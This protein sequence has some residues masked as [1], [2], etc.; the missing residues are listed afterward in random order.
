MNGITRLLGIA[1]YLALCSVPMCADTWASTAVKV[2]LEVDWKHQYDD[3]NSQLQRREWFD[4]VAEQA[5]RMDALILRSDRKPLDVALR[6][7]EALL[8]DLSAKIKPDLHRDFERKL[9]ALHQRVNGSGSVAGSEEDRR[10]FNDV[11][12]LRREISFANPLLDFDTI[13]FLKHRFPSLQHCCY[14]YYGGSAVPDGGVYSLSKPFSARPEL[15]HL[16]ADSKVKNGRLGGQ[17]L[18]RGSFMSLS[19]SY[20]ASTIYFAHTQCGEKD[21][22]FDRNADHW[23]LEKTWHIFRANADG[24]GLEQLTDG[25]CN[26]FDPY[27]LPNG[28]LVFLSERRGGFGRCHTI[29][30]PI[31]VLHSMRTD[32]SDIV[33][34][35]YH[36]TNEWHPSVNN[37]GMIIYTRWDY[38]DRGDCIAH[39]PWITYPDGR[40]PRAIQGN[41]PVA[42]KGRPDM[43]LHVRAIPGSN[44]YVSTA[45]GHH[46]LAY[47][48]LI[49]ID[50]RVEDDGAMAPIRR[51][52]PEVPF[53]ESEENENNYEKR[54]ENVYIYG[55]AWPLNE[56]YYLAVYTP[57]G[58]ESLGIYL[59]DAF[60]NR[61]LLYRDPDIHCIHPLPLRSRKT[62]PE[63]PHATALGLPDSIP[64]SAPRENG[65]PETGTITCLNVY[66]G[67]KPW[68]EGIRIT[69]LRVIQLFP[70]ATFSMD[71]PNIGVASESLARGVLGTVPVEEDGSVR[72]T[73]PARKAIYFQALDENGLAVQSMMS[74]AYVHPGEQLACQ[75]CHER[76]QDAP[77]QPAKPLFA[78]RRSPSQLKPDVEGTYPLSFPRLVQPVLDRSCVPCH[79]KDETGK[80]PD[81]AGTPLDVSAGKK[82]PVSQWSRSF[83]SLKGYA[84]GSSGKPPDR[85]PVRTTPGKFGA[86]ASK[87]YQM[88]K[89]GHHDLKLSDEDMHRITVW[90]DGNSNFY[91]AYHDT[92]RQMQGERVMPVLE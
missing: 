85:Q 51:L 40:D 32:G 64:A 80:A 15:K 11:C 22:V 91:G 21:E 24:S 78:L 39:H 75:G 1:A 57:A 41:Y 58:R 20:D 62:P 4:T 3:L 47:G 72:F 29:A 50:P 88:L 13:V 69:D 67:L 63:I 84:N 7:T 48:S 33:P 68:P 65:N 49:I 42:R 77:A 56:L 14:Q 8:K 46:R 53:P 5:F 23:T 55:T 2:E 89:Q 74:A 10:L 79:Q 86:Q 61:E 35:S 6:R 44:R 25:T 60:G 92:E 37:D 70:K 38:V 45:T 83:L 9:K 34:L 16:L 76:R 18:E 52:T 66:K 31:Y 73:A 27:P 81:L 17:K 36:E 87:L 12:Q 90:L 54:R 28:R 30:M 82:R 59:I 26:D 19:L 71:Y 43:E